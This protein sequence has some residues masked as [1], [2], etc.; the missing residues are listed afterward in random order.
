MRSTRKRRRPG[1]APQ[2]PAPSKLARLGR[3]ALYTLFGLL[4]LTVAWFIARQYQHIRAAQV[5]SIENVQLIPI[6]PPSAEALKNIFSSED[7]DWPPQDTVPPFAVQALPYG[8]DTLDKAEK[9]TV[10]Y[11]ALLPIVLAE[12]SRIWNE[13]VFLLQQF[14]LGA[15]D[16][17]S[18]AGREVA[19]IADR[20]RV[21]GDLNEPATRDTLLRRVDVVPV[22]LVLAQAAQESGWGTSRFALE[23]NNLFGIWTW[24]EDAGSVPLNRRTDATHMVRVYPDIETSVRAYL[25]NINIGFAYTDFRDLRADMRSAGKPLDPFALAGTLDRYSAAGDIYVNDIRQMLHS[26]ELDKLSALTLDP[27]N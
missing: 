9:K 24:D 13:R 25:H 12:N 18:D 26:N 16:V 15:V 10:F 22:T 4:P 21:D 3:V 5:P 8:L 11:R 17:Q 6:K 2:K 19:R 14:G 23:S 27:M 1:R 7:Y 20:Y